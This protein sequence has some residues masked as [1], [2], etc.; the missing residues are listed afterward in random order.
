MFVLIFAWTSR[1]FLSSRH[2]SAQAPHGQFTL[3]SHLKITTTNDI[4]KSKDFLNRSLS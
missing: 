3:G 4:G 1:G 2:T